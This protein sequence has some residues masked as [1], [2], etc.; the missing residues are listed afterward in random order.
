LGLS[1]IFILGP[2]ASALLTASKAVNSHYVSSAI[3]DA[4][5]NAIIQFFGFVL[6]Y[7]F[8]GIG[9]MHQY[10]VAKQSSPK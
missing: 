8:L 9:L 2:S 1:A 3:Q 10:K 4:F 6:L 5:T 7:A